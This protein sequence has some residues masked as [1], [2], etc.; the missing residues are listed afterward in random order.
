[1][2]AVHYGE[3]KKRFMENRMGDVCLGWKNVWMFVC[4]EYK[5]PHTHREV[6]CCL[7]SF[8]NTT[9]CSR[10]LWGTDSFHLGVYHSVF[11]HSQITSESLWCFHCLPI[12]GEQ[13]CLRVKGIPSTQRDVFIFSRSLFHYMEKNSS[14]EG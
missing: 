11:F 8:F 10:P 2:F 3:Y 14:T 13:T 7:L 12:S 1:M 9:F 5:Q 6:E 4:I